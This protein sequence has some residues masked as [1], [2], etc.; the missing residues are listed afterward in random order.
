[1][2]KITQYELICHHDESMLNDLSK[3][4][5]SSLVVFKGKIDVFFLKSN[6]DKGC[7]CGIMAKVL[8]SGLERS[9]NSSHPVTFT[10]R[11]KPPYTPLQ[12]WIK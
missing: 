6:F 4:S 5:K 2:L 12:L 1:M 11:L 10:F 9:S 7:P 8:D 3:L